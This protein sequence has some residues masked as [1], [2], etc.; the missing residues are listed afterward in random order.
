MTSSIWFIS[1]LLIL[2][3]IIYTTNAYTS[4]NNL[5]TKHSNVKCLRIFSEYGRSCKDIG[6]LPSEV[7][8]MAQDTCSYSQREGKECGLYPTCKKNTDGGHSP[9]N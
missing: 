1:H 5:T 2:V 6:C 9:G 7:C 3:S 4:K 8:A